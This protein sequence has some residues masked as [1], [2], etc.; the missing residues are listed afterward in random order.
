MLLL[1]QAGSSGRAVSQ[2]EVG[3]RKDETGIG[4]ATLLEDR[5]APTTTPWPKFP[6]PEPP[7][8]FAGGNAAPGRDSSVSP[9][10]MNKGYAPTH[11][12]ARSFSFGGD[13]TPGRDPSV[14]PKK[15][16][17]GCAPTPHTQLQ[18]F[19]Q[20]VSACRHVPGETLR[21]GA[22][23]LPALR[24]RAQVRGQGGPPHHALPAHRAGRAVFYVGLAKC[25]GGSGSRIELR[26]GGP[27]PHVAGRS[28]KIPRS[29]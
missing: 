8:R 18:S 14:S 4:D 28:P 20:D 7:L 17:H 5:G 21:W 29:G 23:L 11:T 24:G 9:K 15:M 19:P 25:S 12:I 1:R 16:N 26:P 3:V 13:A 6:G 22:T 10:K 2:A 27:P